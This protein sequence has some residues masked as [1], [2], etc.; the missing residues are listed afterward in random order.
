MASAETPPPTTSGSDSFLGRIF[1]VLFNPKP[2]FASIV[3]RPT[4][5]LPLILI[6]C[7]SVIVIFVFGHRVGWRDFMI[8]Q[9]QQSARTQK[10]MESMTAE[11]REKMIDTQTKWAS[12]ITYPAVVL[13]TFIYAVII[14]AV[15]MLV[16]NLI[17]GTKI[18]F[19]PSLAIVAHSWVPGIIGGL[20]AILILFL[21]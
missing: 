7:V 13:G 12:I 5:V 21:K 16:F 3:R 10:Q 18:G 9:D 14:A 17:Y 19:V 15:L 20:L 11:Q 8:R 4:W 2:T 6:V 1:A